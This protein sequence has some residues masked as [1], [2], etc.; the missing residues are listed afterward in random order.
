MRGRNWKTSSACR[1]VARNNDAT[2]TATATTT[3]TTTTTT[4]GIIDHPQIG[5]TIPETEN[6]LL[7]KLCEK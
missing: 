3:T 1:C 7:R 6:T 2:T 5:N 4:T